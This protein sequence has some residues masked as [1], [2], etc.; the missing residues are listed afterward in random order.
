MKIYLPFFYTLSFICERLFSSYD[1]RT[2]NNK[3][4]QLFMNPENEERIK[5]FRLESIFMR[6]LPK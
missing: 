2:F 6:E 1:K 3:V 4:F 5:I